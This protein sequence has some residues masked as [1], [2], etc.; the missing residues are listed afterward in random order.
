MNNNHFYKQYSISRSKSGK[1]YRKPYRP[2]N[3]YAKKLSC[4]LYSTSPRP[5]KMPSVSPSG[6]NPYLGETSPCGKPAQELSITQVCSSN[7]KWHLKKICSGFII[8]ALPEAKVSFLRGSDEIL[9]RPSSGLTR[10][11]VRLKSSS[12]ENKCTVS[13]WKGSLQKTWVGRE[14]K[15]RK[16][17]GEQIWEE[18]KTGIFEKSNFMLCNLHVLPSFP[19]TF[20]VDSAIW[21]SSYCV[22]SNRLRIQSWA[23][24]RAK[25][26][27]LF[28]THSSSA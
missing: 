16:L 22:V 10:T 23:L 12:E 27:V 25:K 4:G 5:Y 26:I 9:S 1:W 14:W 7:C 11:S 15:M 3:W 2:L 18:N 13:L 17:S 19:F 8:D 21:G 6:A 20:I 24:P 28:V